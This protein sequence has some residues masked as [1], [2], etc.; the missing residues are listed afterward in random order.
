MRTTTKTLKIK[1][2]GHKET[3][4]NFARISNGINVFEGKTTKTKGKKEVHVYVYEK[5]QRVQVKV[6]QGLK[7][8]IIEKDFYKLYN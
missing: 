5:N 6:L 2:E 4:I 3:S 8:L 7:N 1:I